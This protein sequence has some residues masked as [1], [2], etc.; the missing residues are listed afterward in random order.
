MA[1]YLHPRRRVR[2]Y[3]TFDVR[4][5]HTDLSLTI[6]P[7]NTTQ[8]RRF[9]TTA[10][11]VSPQLQKC[12]N[13]AGTQVDDVTAAADLTSCTIDL[14]TDTVLADHWKQNQSTCSST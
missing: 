12:S 5:G 10:W 7:A 2:E 3:L 4:L 6:S 13:L 11:R 8:H 1:L 14:S 9:I